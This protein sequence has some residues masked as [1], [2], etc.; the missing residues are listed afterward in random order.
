VSGIVRTWIHA[1]MRSNDQPNRCLAIAFALRPLITRRCGP[2]NGVQLR[3][4]PE[5][6]LH[7]TPGRVLQG[8]LLT[9]QELRPRR[10]RIVPVG[11][12]VE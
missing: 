4:P 10:R 6:H 8:N 9:R 1:G 11:E 3:C 5:K 2:Q 12:R 7:V